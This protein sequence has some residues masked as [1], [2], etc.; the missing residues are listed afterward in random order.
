[1]NKRKGEHIF[2]F[3]FAL[4]MVCSSYAAPAF[5]VTWVYICIKY[6]IRFKFINVPSRRRNASIADNI[7]EFRLRFFLPAIKLI[8]ASSIRFASSNAAFEWDAFSFCYN[9]ELARQSNTEANN[10]YR[11]TYDMCLC[12]L[13]NHQ[14]RRSNQFWLTRFS[15]ARI[16][17]HDDHREN[18]FTMRRT[19]G[20][21]RH[22]NFMVYENEWYSTLHNCL[23]YSIWEFN[24]IV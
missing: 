10:V 7:A 24:S 2:R 17:W 6:S 20:D 21:S 1:M 4:F 23:L 9:T 16:I 11:F 8:W 22:L 18:K 19:A 5:H 15:F 13:D 14:T 12:A 3:H